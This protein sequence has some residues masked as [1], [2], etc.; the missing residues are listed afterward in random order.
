MDRYSLRHQPSF[1]MW[2]SGDHLG[3]PLYEAA[4]LGWLGDGGAVTPAVLEV[5]EDRLV[6]EHVDEWRPSSESA[7]HLGRML[8]R[9]HASGAPWYGAPPSGY[10]GPAWIGDATLKV[11][12]TPPQESKRSWGNFYSQLRIR[13]YLSDVFDKREQDVI[14]QL[15]QA[16]ESGVLDHDEPEMVRR[17]G[18]GV[19]RIHGDLWIGNVLWGKRSPVLIDPAA[20]GGHAE[21][22]L[23]ALR[24]FG[25][26]YL[27]HVIAAYQEV[28]ALADGWEGRVYLHQMHIL[29]VHCFLFGRSYV[30][31]TIEAARNAL[32]LT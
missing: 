16:L 27:E 20:Q 13:P 2:A 8:A 31:R 12:Q 29:T 1:T 26:L 11:Q 19:S 5:S 28:S 14:E 30:P 10:S 9:M 32:A 3:Q 24:T 4:G 6:T 23:A 15:C 18:N 25:C 21:E 7:R 22:D 17:K